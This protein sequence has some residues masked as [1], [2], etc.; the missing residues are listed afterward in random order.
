MQQPS[1]PDSSPSGVPW[2]G[3]EILLALF[4]VLTWPLLVSTFL[5][6]VGLFQD[7]YGA[8]MVSLVRSE[9]PPEQKERAQQRRVA[10]N[11][12]NLWTGV[13]AFP[14]QAASVLLLL[15]ALSRTRPVQLGL[16]TR[17]LGANLLAGLLVFLG[18]AP[19]VLAVNYLAEVLYRRAAGGVPQVHPFTLI[20]GQNLLPAEWVLLVVSGTVAAPVL[21]EL[22]FRGLLQ[23]WLVARAWGGR[24]AM[25]AAFGIAL[26]YCAGSAR[27]A[28][29]G[30]A[31]AGLIEAAP[32]LF[33]LSLVP[34]YL[35]VAYRSRTP[36]AGAIFGTAA[37]FAAVHSGVWPSPVALFLL[38]LAL[39]M[40]AWRTRSL[41]GPILL[42]S[43]F[44]AIACVQLLWP[45]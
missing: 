6:S 17:R 29:S 11:R 38:G 30:G 26:A 35:V 3:A 32:A 10:V 33:V 12:F 24:A 5:D 27:N 28:W 9:V 25:A 4:V 20:A 8:E 1:E 18:V 16:T 13:F 19:V 15:H 44:N 22:L 41:V 40:L 14:L 23:P 39:G 45:T 34:V 2:S 37:L 21:E 42:H 7:L 43:L 31:G 36:A